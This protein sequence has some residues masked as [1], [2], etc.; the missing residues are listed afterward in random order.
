MLNYG[1]YVFR[2]RYVVSGYT[3]LISS[4]GRVNWEK[5][6][7][8]YNQYTPESKAKVTRSSTHDALEL[9]MNCTRLYS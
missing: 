5:R 7:G 3:E 9:I 8:G 4:G 6:G 2:H 1:C